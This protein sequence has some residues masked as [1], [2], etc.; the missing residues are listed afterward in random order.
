MSECIFC[1]IIN[2]E[3]PA[4]IEYEDDEI[5]AFNDIDPQAPV[6]ILVIPKKH[7]VNNLALSEDDLSIMAKIFKVLNALAEEKN[8]SESGFRIVNNC[9]KDGGQAV[10]HIHFHLLGGR[11]MQWPPG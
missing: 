3:I 2:K 8:I 6:H 1:K 4:K 7:I 11:A 10:D 9:L 5:I